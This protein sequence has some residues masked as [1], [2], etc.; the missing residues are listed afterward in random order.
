M[1]KFIASFENHNAYQQST[2]NEINTP[3]VSLC[4]SED[5]IHYQEKIYAHNGHEYIE[6]GGLKWATMNLGANSVT[7]IGLAYRWGETQGYTMEYGQ[8]NINNGNP[9]PNYKFSM[10]DDN[11]GDYTYTK[12]NDEDGLITLQLEDD[13]V[14]VAWGGNWRMSTVSDWQ[15]LI[16][17]TNF[18]ITKNYQG[19]GIGGVIFIDKIDNSKTLFLPGYSSNNPN[20]DL[21][22]MYQINSIYTSY[23]EGYNF[24][25]SFSEYPK[26][27]YNYMI[28]YAYVNEFRNIRGII[29]E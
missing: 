17:R 18:I 26:G 7:D 29:D 20:N 16:D 13:A 22:I 8:S 3:N 4:R 11:I 1:G 21:E 15:T 27:H 24:Q 19:S 6:I 14:H 28:G 2:F 10:Y 12:Y 5:E 9:V 23:G 25:I